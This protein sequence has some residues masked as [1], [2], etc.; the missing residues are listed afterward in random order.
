VAGSQGEKATAI[1]FTKPYE[2]EDDAAED[3]RK[4]IKFLKHYAVFHASQIE[5]VP[6][7]KPPSIEEAP[8]ARPEAADI[9]LKNK[10]SCRAY[11]R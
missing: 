5:G 4:T 6:A 9:I 2:V 8:W 10:R 3:G 1:F 11:R 7:Y